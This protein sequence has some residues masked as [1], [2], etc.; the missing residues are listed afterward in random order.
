MTAEKLLSRSLK[1]TATPTKGA[2]VMAHGVRDCWL[3]GDEDRRPI[4]IRRREKRVL[5]VHAHS[6]AKTLRSHHSHAGHVFFPLGELRLGVK[7]MHLVLDHAL[8]RDRLPCHHAMPFAGKHVRTGEKNMHSSQF[9]VVDGGGGGGVPALTAP[10]P[11][12]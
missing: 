8:L 3:C 6:H 5:C 11:S 9:R 2:M 12:S 4:H 10:R 7:R 1:A